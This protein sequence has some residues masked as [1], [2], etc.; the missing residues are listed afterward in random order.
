[1]KPSTSFASL[2]RPSVAELA[3]VRG[4]S[5][6]SRILANSATCL[7]FLALAFASPAR[8]ADWPAFR[9]PTGQGHADPTEKGLPVNWSETENVTW[10]TEL[11]GRGW[12]SPSL[13]GNQIWMTTAA[14]EDRSLRALCVDRTTGKL[15]HDI[16]VF[17]LEQTPKVHSK[18]TPA[19]PSATIE[20][21]RV[22][23]HF[24]TLGTAALD[25]EG[26]ILWKNNELKFQHVHG[27]AG[28]PVLYKGLLLLN[29]DGGD[30]QFMVALD[31]QTGQVHWQADRKGSMAY[32]T[33]LVIQVAGKDQVVS[34][35]GEWVFSYE[36]GTGKELWKC[37]YPSGYSN[38]PRPVFADG[39]VFVSSGYNNP[40]LYAIRPDGEGDITETHVAWKMEKGAPLNPSP[41]ALDERLY[42]VSD[43]G[44]L[45]CLDTKTGKELWKS[46]VPGNY[47]SSFVYADGRIYIQN[48]TGITTVFAPGD[49]FE[50]LATN[51]L[52]GRTLATLSPSNGALYLRTDKHLYRIE[53]RP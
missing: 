33:P 41:L 19:S 11:P 44:V 3:R 31:K 2:S 35:C 20:G 46:R 16:E 29:C 21:G 45:S 36:P 47:S 7:A 22:Y 27:P 10:K 49:K 1:M 24:G 18:N 9:G 52:E 43:G 51:E 42:V 28:S 37:R 34:P 15:V 48:E 8:A 50:K 38:V 14:D 4:S 12:S 25:T 5:H 53:K 23:V 32:S 6:N 39:I 13:V 26:K 17:R 40:V 30:K